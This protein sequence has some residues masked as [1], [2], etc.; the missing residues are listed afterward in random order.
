MSSGSL[1]G[2]SVDVR[3]AQHGWRGDG[4]GDAEGGAI[5]DGGPFDV[6]T[7]PSQRWSVPSAEGYHGCVGHGSRARADTPTRRSKASQL[8]SKPSVTG[9]G[10]RPRRPR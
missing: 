6:A 9:G 2:C 8:S 7:S 4:G 5:G 10:T 3:C 1:E